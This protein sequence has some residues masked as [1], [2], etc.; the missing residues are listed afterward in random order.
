MRAA[1]RMLMQAT[2][3]AAMLLTAACGGGV[4]NR[5]EVEDVVSVARLGWSGADVELR[6]TNRLHRD[7][8]LES[9]RVWFRTRSGVLAEAELRGGA[10][11]ARRT[12]EQVRMRF[13]VSSANPSAMPALWRRLAAGETDDIWIDAEAAV[14]IGGRERKIYA[15][16]R[17]LSE[18]LSNFGVP[19]AALPAWFQ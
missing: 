15:Q 2:A 3:V 5:V 7:L 10:A 17:R 19:E 11:I 12:T 9:C 4:R 1:G 6:V 8:S 14:R 13:R 18:I 16:G